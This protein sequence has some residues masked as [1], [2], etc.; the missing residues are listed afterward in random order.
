MSIPSY[1]IFRKPIVLQF[2]KWTGQGG[3][4]DCGS[5]IAVGG[6]CKAPGRKDGDSEDCT[7]QACRVNM[8][9]PQVANILSRHV[10]VLV[11]S[12][13]IL[14]RNHLKKI[15]SATTIAMR[16]RAP[17]LEPTP[18]PTFAPSLRPEADVDVDEDVAVEEDVGVVEDVFDA[19]DAGLGVILKPRLCNK[20][21]LLKPLLALVWPDGSV[22]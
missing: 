4:P 18:M 20:P 21:S 17:I 9:D 22:I 7:P 15:T 19:L 1:L 5:Q 11:N 6:T 3:K 13:L 8:W 12:Q 16:K 14:H 10:Y 2:I